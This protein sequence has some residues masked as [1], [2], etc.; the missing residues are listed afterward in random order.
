MGKFGLV[1]GLFFGRAGS[2]DIFP[3]E[4]RAK[5]VSM[6]NSGHYWSSVSFSFHWTYILKLYPDFIY[7]N[8]DDIA[9]GSVMRIWPFPLRCLAHG[10][11]G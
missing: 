6:G 11:A 10:T 9:T 7:P 1:L 3:A 8:D 2:V 4:D 5:S